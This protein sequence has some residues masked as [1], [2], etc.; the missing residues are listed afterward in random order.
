[1]QVDGVREWST[2]WAPAA[3]GKDIDVPAASRLDLRDRR[4]VRF[5]PAPLLRHVLAKHMAYSR[6]ASFLHQTQAFST[7]RAGRERAEE[8]RKPRFVLMLRQTLPN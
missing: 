6:S 5:G 8:E 2:R 7:I 3:R 4:H 1:M